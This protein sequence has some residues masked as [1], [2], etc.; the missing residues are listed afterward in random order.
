M[1]GSSI[2]GLYEMGFRSS[3]PCVTQDWDEW[4]DQNLQGWAQDFTLNKLPGILM[5]TEV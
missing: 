1:G 3:S 4:M 5:H 2:A